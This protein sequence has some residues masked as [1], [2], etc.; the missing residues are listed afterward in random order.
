MKCNLCEGNPKC[1]QYCPSGAIE[2]KE[3]APGTMGRKKVIAE[4]FSE[5]FGEVNE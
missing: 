2:F 3:A 4:K 1:A 5:L